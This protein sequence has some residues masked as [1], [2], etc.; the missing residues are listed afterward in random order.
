VDIP[1]GRRRIGAVEL[2]RG[3]HD[4][5]VEGRALAHDLV[6]R[7]ERLGIHARAV[8]AAA[9]ALHGP[10]LVDRDAVLP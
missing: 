1:W 4:D 7:V 9:E 2:L 5:R 3:G 8:G 10:T 6:D